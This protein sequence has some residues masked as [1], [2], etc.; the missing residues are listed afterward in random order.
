MRDDRADSSVTRTARWDLPREQRV[1][2]SGKALLALGDRCLR[3]LPG[4]G[5]R[6]STKAAFHSTQLGRGQHIRLSGR[7]KVRCGA[8]GSGGLTGK[9]HSAREST[10]AQND[11][12]SNARFFQHDTDVRLEEVRPVGRMKPSWVLRRLHWAGTRRLWK[13]ETIPRS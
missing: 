6:R 11:A 10:L 1:E 4:P 13:L 9:L 5:G 8:G 12:R 3:H 2:A 7:H